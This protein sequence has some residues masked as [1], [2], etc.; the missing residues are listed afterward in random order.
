MKRMPSKQ[1]FLT[2]SEIAKKLGYKGAT[3]GQFGVFFTGRSQLD[4]HLGK[5]IN[6]LWADER[7]HYEEGGH[8]RGH[9]FESLRALSKFPQW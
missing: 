5:V 7:K 4:H 8:P 9:I 6:Y 3:M 1:T 2:A